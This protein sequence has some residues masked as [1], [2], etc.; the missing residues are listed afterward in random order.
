MGDPQDQI[1]EEQEELRNT[2]MSEWIPQRILIVNGLS[3]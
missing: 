1:I 3:S 2:I